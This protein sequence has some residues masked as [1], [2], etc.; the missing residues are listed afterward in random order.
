MRE[1][2]ASFK[3]NPKY[4]ACIWVVFILFAIIGFF[5]LTKWSFFKLD[6][7]VIWLLACVAILYLSQKMTAKKA[8]TN[9]IMIILGLLLVLLSLLNIP[10]GFGNPPYSIGDF[11]ILLSGISLVFFGFKGYRSFFLPTILP[12]V[13][14]IGFQLY[15]KFQT[16][17]EWIS[18]PL[19]P[20]IV[21]ST[22]FFLRILRA[23]YTVRENIIT[24]LTIPGETVTLII[25]ENCT[26]IWSLGT[27]TI[28]CLIVLASFPQARNAKSYLLIFI[29]YLG[30]IASN[31]LRVWF[32]L[33]VG[34]Y[35]GSYAAVKSAHDY[36]GWLIFSV[37]V[38]VFWYVF[39]RYHLKISITGKNTRV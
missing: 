31:I 20:P 36:F 14:V 7:F 25:T 10:L 23:N 34:Y 33:F 32:I 13:A 12:A 22:T 6:A 26:G 3:N 15:D 17:L 37:W 29:G 16:Y 8:K 27:F 21:V 2:L 19:I 38:I 39:I 9:W 4:I 24:Y 11:S 28:S 5:S 1:M 18:K 35:W 30:T